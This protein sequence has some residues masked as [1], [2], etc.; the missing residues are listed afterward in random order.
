LYKSLTKSVT[1]YSSQNCDDRLKLAFFG[2]CDQ[3]WYLGI[4]YKNFRNMDKKLQKFK[5][6]EFSMTKFYNYHQDYIK[7]SCVGQIFS[8]NHRHRANITR[9]TEIDLTLTRSSKKSYIIML[10]L[11]KSIHLM[12]L[13]YLLPE[14]HLGIYKRH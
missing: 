4:S 2:H 12:R 7:R 3:M 9:T 5:L 14:C 6:P 11:L 13:D 10:L 8:T 1:K